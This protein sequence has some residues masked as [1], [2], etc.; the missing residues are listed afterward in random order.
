LSH[1]PRAPASCTAVEDV[2]SQVASP[3]IETPLRSE[4]LARQPRPTGP[5]EDNNLANHSSR[6]RH[7]QGNARE[8][9]DQGA[10]EAQPPRA[11]SLQCAQVALSDAVAAVLAHGFNNTIGLVTFYLIG[12][13]YGPWRFFARDLRERLDRPRCAGRGLITLWRIGFSSDGGGRCK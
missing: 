10:G 3:A 8:R 6:L 9:E 11:L 12:P 1:P 7:V 5:V 13:I 2:T 4:Q